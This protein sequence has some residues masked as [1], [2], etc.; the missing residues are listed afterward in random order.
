[1]E[2]GHL[3]SDALL[4][5]A[6]IEPTSDA[7]MPLKALICSLFRK[8]E[9]EGAMLSLDATVR[10]ACWDRIFVLQASGDEHENCHKIP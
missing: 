3:L 9:D 7:A 6:R 2:R 4:V 1:V 10:L 5:E 8:A